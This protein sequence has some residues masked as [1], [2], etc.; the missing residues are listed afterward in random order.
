MLNTK[1]SITVVEY[2]EETG[3]L[4]FD[5]DEEAVKMLCQVGI[6][7]LLADY[8]EEFIDEHEDS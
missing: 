6:N 8:L 7:K 4:S 2:D 5:A 1:G 3:I